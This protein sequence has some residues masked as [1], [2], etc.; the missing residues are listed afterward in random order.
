[1]R[2]QWLQEVVVTEPARLDLGSIERE[3]FIDAT[4]EIVYEV[5]SDPK[6]VREWW[7][8]EADYPVEVGAS[9][10]IRFRDSAG[11]EKVVAL[12]VVEALPPR[13]FSF[14]WAYTPDETA[15]IGRSLLVTFELVPSGT[16]TLV[17]FVETG[18]RQMG[19]SPARHEETYRDH[20]S[21]WDYFL[22]RLVA[23]AGGSGS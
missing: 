17:K 16:G 4:P 8:E 21:G 22:P 12:T 5:V 1:M 20:V 9:G 11:V 13:T 7:P 10:G 18:F 3:I 19:W 14:R 15:P 2:N 6:H 23:Y